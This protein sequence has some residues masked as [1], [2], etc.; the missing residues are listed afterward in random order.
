MKKKFTLGFIAILFTA[1]SLMAQ[2]VAETETPAY[3]TKATITKLYQIGITEKQ[4]VKAIEVFTSYYQQRALN[5][6]QSPAADIENRNSKLKTIFTP[7]QMV[8]FKEKLE[9]SVN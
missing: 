6:A 3:K 5:A 9:P 4:R 7:D 8:M 2:S 1:G